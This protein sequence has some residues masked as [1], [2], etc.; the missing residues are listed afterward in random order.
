[1]LHEGK[2]ITTGTPDEIKASDNPVVKQFVTGSSEG[3]ISVK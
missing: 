1:M 3:P 2:I